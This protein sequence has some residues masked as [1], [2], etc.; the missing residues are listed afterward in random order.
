MLRTDLEAGTRHHFIMPPPRMTAPIVPFESW[1]EVRDRLASSLLGGSRRALLTGSAGTGKT[2]LIDNVARVLR[3]A[4]RSV[5]VQLADADPAPPSAGTILFVDEADR[6]SPAQ[7]TALLAAPGSVVLAGLE[8]LAPRR[9]AAGTVH[10]R[11][12]PLDREAA[13]SYVAE[14]LAQVG[15]VPADLESQA[16]RRLVELSGGVPRLLSTLLS[17]SAWLA[18]MNGAAVISAAH[19]EE[20]AEA[21]CVLMPV[22]PAKRRMGRGRAIG[23][24]LLL[25]GVM[26]GVAIAAAP[27]LFPAET[28]RLVERGRALVGR[29]EPTALPALVT[30]TPPA[31]AMAPAVPDTVVASPVAPTAMPAPALAATVPEPPLP[32]PEAAEALPLETVSFLL[33]RGREMFRLE[34]VSAARLLF[35]RAADGGSAEAML[36]LG[37][38]FDPAV[39]GRGAANLADR[40]QAR[41]WYE[42][43][44]AAGDTEATELLRR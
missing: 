22:P 20:A 3:A 19:V 34:D 40:E 18:E 33:R 42:R 16:L 15:R 13:R 14:W 4:G 9:L 30:A 1:V 26:L 38:T 11:L 5:T 2:V 6:L 37:R 31:I 28:A 29:G 32:A 41:R 17:A 21:R 27:R 7:R 8:T 10:L 44:S 25:T 39:L 43:A 36:A 23:S 12:Q 35:R 24:G